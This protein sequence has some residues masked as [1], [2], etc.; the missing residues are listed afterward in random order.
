MPDYKATRVLGVTMWNKYMKSGKIVKTERLR[1]NRMNDR[2]S[3]NQKDAAINS[4]F[5]SIVS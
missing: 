5:C 1:G 4:I 3:V 2:M